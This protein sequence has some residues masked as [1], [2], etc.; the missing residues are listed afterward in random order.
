MVFAEV[1]KVTFVER[2]SP[3]SAA[4]AVKNT[5]ELDGMREAHL[6]DSVALA[7]TFHWLEEEVLPKCVDQHGIY[8]VLPLNIATAAAFL[9]KKIS[10]HIFSRETPVAV[11]KA[12]YNILFND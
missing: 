12:D 6:R 9:A 2:P 8:C 11:L 4:K 1:K 3:I 5:A 7:T 10:L